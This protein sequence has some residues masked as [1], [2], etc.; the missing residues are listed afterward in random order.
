MARTAPVPNFP[1]IPGMN[2]GLFV[3]GGGGDGGGSSAGGGGAGKGKQGADGKNGGKDANG[4]GKGAGACGAG[5]ASGCP[6]GHGKSN[7]SAGDPVDVATGRVYTV[8]ATDLEL[9]GPLP[10]VLTRTYSSAARERDVG[11]GFGWAFTLGWSITVRRRTLDVWNGNGTALTFDA[12]APGETALGQDGWEL[13][14]EADGFVLDAG[15]DLVRTFREAQEDGAL[16]RLSEVRDA[17]GNTIALAYEQGRLVEIV[18]SAGRRVR[19]TPDQ[20]G[21]IESL[22]VKNAEHQGRWQVFARY[23]YDADGNLVSV[24]DADGHET[25]FDFG[26]DHLLRSYRH[27]T[28]LTVRFVYDAAGRCVETWGEHPGGEDP[29]LDAA[30]PAVLADNETKARGI[31]HV[32]L[33]FSGDMTEVIDSDGVQRYAVNAFGKLD[34][35]VT[36]SGGVYTRTYDERGH[37]ISYTNALGAT[38]TWERDARGRILAIVNP[39]GHRTELRR[40]AAGRV[41]ELVDPAGHTTRYVYDERGNVRTVLLP[42]G[43]TSSFEYDTR[44]LV[45]AAIAPN[46]ARTS[47]TASGISPR[48]PRRTAGSTASAGPVTGASTA[49]RRRTARRS[50]SASIARGGSAA[51]ATSAAESTSSSAT[52]AGA[53]WRRGCRTA[54]A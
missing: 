32:K 44:G 20:D 15:D 1:A 17:N 35:A 6:A 27:P 26:D 47:T 31:F 18:D 3:L 12:L 38:T 13:R 34:K 41:I 8:P 5:S 48:S 50:T 54:A 45:T 49:T 25:V 19:V 10:L 14:R 9:P 4:G 30:L 23:R 37:E 43:I 21:R 52:P 29:S 22:R 51:C 53:S 33:T 36:G 7:V 40:D 46:G 16:F 39:L 2:P 24:I 28:G 11:L 42:L